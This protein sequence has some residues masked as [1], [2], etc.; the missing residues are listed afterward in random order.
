MTTFCLRRG[1]GLALMTWSLGAA[2]ATTNLFSTQFE[3]AEGYVA[4]ADLAGQQNWGWEGSGG[5]GVIAGGLQGQSAYLGFTPPDPADGS[6]VLYRPININPVAAGFPLVKFSVLLNIAD[7]SNGQYD[8]FRWSVYNLQLNRLFSIDFDN[9]YLDVSYRLDGTNKTVFTNLPI[10]NNSNYLLQVTMDFAANRWSATLN[11]AFIATNQ[12]L[13]TVNAP[14][15]L[16]DIDAVW[17]VNQ[18]SVTNAPGQVTYVNAPGDNYMLFDNYQITAESGAAPAA[19]L[20]FL[21]RTAEGWGLL[22]VNGT[23]GSRWAV[24]ATTNFANWTALRTNQISG[25]S[26]DVVDTTADEFSRRFYRARYA[27]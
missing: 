2:G 13:T 12:P 6:L 17:L 14:L 21:G 8:I 18:I 7:S 4:D 1:I 10:T 26:F 24:E 5:N 15:T 22:R 23:D 19:Q 3:A 16:A 25:G 9:D 11:S 20:R 27:P